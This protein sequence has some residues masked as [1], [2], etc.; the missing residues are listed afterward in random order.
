MSS[1]RGA[2][3]RPGRV[4]EFPLPSK[5]S[6]A[7]CACASASGAGSARAP[8]SGGRRWHGRETD[9]SNSAGERE[10]AGLVQ[11]RA[12]DAA[13]TAPTGAAALL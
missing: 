12:G 7:R 1:R 6:R 11:L 13:T 8:S 10:V 4:G 3:A 2:G 9:G 5:N